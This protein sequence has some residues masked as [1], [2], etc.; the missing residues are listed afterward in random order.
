MNSA[1]C[2]TEHDVSPEAAIAAV[3]NHD[4]PVVIDLD[5]T[6]YLRN[7]TEDFIDSARPRVPALVIMAILDALRPW[8][9]TGGEPTRDAWRVR[10]IM[11]F[12]PWTLWRWR[13]HVTDLAAHFRNTA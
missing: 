1:V 5:E 10:A 11:L 3:R 12:M 4:G 7:S 6:L 13:R 8:R 9:W 2:A